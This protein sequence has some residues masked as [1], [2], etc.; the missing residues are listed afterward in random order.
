MNINESFLQENKLKINMFASALEKY[1]KQNLSESRLDGKILKKARVSIPT[2]RDLYYVMFYGEYAFVVDKVFT[3]QSSNLIF[4]MAKVRLV[5]ITKSIQTC[6]DDG[7]ILHT[8]SHIAA[9]PSYSQNIYQEMVPD[10]IKNIDFK[11][12]KSIINSSIYIK[13]DN[14][15]KDLLAY[16]PEQILKKEI[17]R[18]AKTRNNVVPLCWL[19]TTGDLLYFPYTGLTGSNLNNKSY[20]T[21]ALFSSL[22]NNP[23]SAGVSGWSMLDIVD[24]CISNTPFKKSSVLDF[25]NLFG[26]DRKKLIKMQES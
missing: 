24:L 15:F 12:K 9:S 26:V 7:S 3:E 11:D 6:Y 2:T 19:D 5:P 20:I 22:M 10:G 8:M 18:S 4:F 23:T 13:L 14:F 16:K 1:A 25:P 17:Y 21:T